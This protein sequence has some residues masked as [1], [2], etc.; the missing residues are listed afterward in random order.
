MNKL[1]NASVRFNILAFAGIAIVGALVLGGLAERQASLSGDLADRLLSDVRI[2][3]AVGTVDMMHD[4]VVGV[5]RGAILA[6]MDNDADAHKAVQADLL[7]ASKTMR[8]SLEKVA[9]DAHSAA[10]SQL[11]AEAKPAVDGYLR[12]AQA[13]LDAAQKDVA[14]AKALR[15][16]FDAQ[17]RELET[18]LDK[19]S[20][21][22]ESMAEADVAHRDALYRQQAAARAATLV[23][24]VLALAVFGL[25]FAR[26]LTHR[27]GAEPVELSHFARQIASGE[28]H[29]ELAG[30][31]PRP[32]SLAATMVDMRDQLRQ[33]VGL[34]REGADSV[35]VGSS[36][37][38][39]GNQNLASR[40]ELQATKLQQTATG[41]GELTDS[42]RQ[43]ADNAQAASQ[44][45]SQASAVALRGGEAV[46]RVVAT[47]SEIQA[48]SHKIAEIT[49][50][51]DGIA[52]Q[53]NILALNAAVEAARAGEQGRGFAV[54]ASEVRSLAQRSAGAA[55]EIK[56]LIESSVQ[57]V[58]TGNKLVA[59]AGKTMQ[60]IVSQVK[61]VHELI[62]DIT[63]ATGHQNSGVGGMNQSVA[64]LDRGT[65]QNA[66]LVEESA[67][68]AHML[69]DQAS[70]LLLAVSK[71]Q[72]ASVEGVR[73]EA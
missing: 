16:T 49:S 12:S 45:A 9:T 37:I 20:G 4:Y 61:R 41:M 27:L 65:Q 67:R 62:N 23:V 48:S 3:R 54:V 39:T 71:F 7:E 22:I 8:E 1:K 46:H 57:T 31:T 43:T 13:I 24:T 30:N 50:V 29:A 26:S 14:A 63:A 56:T 11:V 38:A 55:R 25:R 60:D 34:I 40:T 6:G 32:G 69:S 18:R 5:T 10:I 70:R 59:D 73:T 52:F 36:Q 2:T 19:L 33:T 44:L 66:S 28:L 68:A 58:D 15:P 51:I 35:A 42:L 47:M 21:A 64:E 17:F 53:T 72:L